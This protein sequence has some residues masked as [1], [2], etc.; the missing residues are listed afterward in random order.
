M[1]SRFS[2]ATALLFSATALFCT[3]CQKPQIRV[4]TVPKDPPR[5]PARTAGTEQSA[6]ERVKPKVTWTLPEGWIETPPGEVS[7]AAFAVKTDA[8]E[9][10]VNITPLPNLQGNEAMVANM[11][12]QQ[13]GLPPIQQSEIT[14]VLQPVE[15]AGTEGHLLEINGMNNG[16]PVRMITAIAHRDGRSWFYRISGDDALVAAQKAT[17]LEFLKTV[18][19]E[20]SSNTE[21]AATAPTAAP[22][23]AGTKP[24]PGLNAAT[25]AG[26][27][28][29]AP[30]QMQVAKFTVP[31]RDGAKAEVSVSVF[32]SDS[33]GTLAN[34][35]RWRQQLGQPAV[36]EAGLAALVSPL[37]PNRPDALLVSLNHEPRA[38]LGAIVPRASQ[39]WFYKLVGD[40][41]AVS[42]EREAFIA[43]AKTNP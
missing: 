2:S 13:V 40:A 43:F 38:M 10:M 17:F 27:T 25:P 16:K 7:V 41:P 39:W 15:V 34:V 9:A 20:A 24:P 30:G 26:W 23:S 31:E 29:V 6:P 8:G 35:N 42:A 14:S 28:A 4:Y 1:T 18:S 19:V 37:D 33:G 22:G 32:P 5:E 12:R 21:N 36:D 11:Y 3:S